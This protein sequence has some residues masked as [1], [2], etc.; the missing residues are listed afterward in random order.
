MG[1][2]AYTEIVSPYV[3]NL[4]ARSHVQQ[5]I[6]FEKLILVITLFKKKQD[7]LILTLNFT[8]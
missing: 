6:W 1:A 2:G 7:P 5:R 3:V 4:G 8:E